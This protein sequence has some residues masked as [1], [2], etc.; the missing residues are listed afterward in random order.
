[1]SD[2]CKYNY[3]YNNNRINTYI[4]RICS[5]EGGVMED[6]GGGWGCEGIAVK[7]LLLHE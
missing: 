2:L 3:N 1:M 6:G 5:I 7:L 4:T